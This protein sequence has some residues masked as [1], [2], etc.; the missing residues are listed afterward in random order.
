M[1]HPRIINL[2][3][4]SHF[5]KSRSFL[6]EHRRTKEQD[7]CIR[8]YRPRN[9]ASLVFQEKS[10]AALIGRL[11]SFERRIPQTVNGLGDPCRDAADPRLTTGLTRRPLPVPDAQAGVGV[12]YFV[13][14]AH[15]ARLKTDHQPEPDHRSYYC[16]LTLPPTAETVEQREALQHAADCDLEAGRRTALT[17]TQLRQ[18]AGVATAHFSC[19]IDRPEFITE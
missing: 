7:T 13:R 1:S 5:R 9:A 15:P 16:A 18:R 12:E 4:A 11:F 17:K 8:I 6:S 14:T 19:A 10:L 3:V 2:S